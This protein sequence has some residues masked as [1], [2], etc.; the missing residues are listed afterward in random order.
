MFPGALA[1]TPTAISV[2]VLCVCAVCVCVFVCVCVCVCVCVMPGRLL[3]DDVGA[4]VGAVAAD[5][6][7]LVN[8]VRCDGIHDAAEDR[9]RGAGQGQRK[10]ERVSE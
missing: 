3:A 6:V 2:R 4:A 7:E 1:A 5:N 9:K 8:A 10:R